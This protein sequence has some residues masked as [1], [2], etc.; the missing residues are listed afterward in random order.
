MQDRVGPLG[1]AVDNADDHDLPPE[2]AK[3]L[4]D[5]VFYTHLDVFRREFLGDPPARV[6][7]MSVRLSPGARAVRVT[8]RASPI[9]HIAGDEKCRLYLLSRWLTRSEGSV[10]AHAS[11]TYTEVLF[12]GSDKF[13]TKE[14]VRGEIGGRGGWQTH[15]WYGDGGSLAGF[16][17]AVPGGV[18]WPPRDLGAGQGRLS[19]ETAVGVCPPGGDRTPGGRW[20]DGSA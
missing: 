19:E 15:P 2:C 6:K 13:P 17:R 8:P 20:D 1:K 10:Y 11:V 5:I 9:V 4:R 14:V 7:P 12:A 3:M 18:P 16:R